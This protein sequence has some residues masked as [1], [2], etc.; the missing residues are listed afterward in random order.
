VTNHRQEYQPLLRC[1][2]I[3]YC[4]T[5][6]CVCLPLRLQADAFPVELDNDENTLSYYGVCDGAQ[7]LMNEIDL[8]ARRRDMERLSI[9]QD[10]RILQ[11]EQDVIAMQEIKQRNQKN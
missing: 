9:E 2:C 5:Q 8:E 3:Y 11:Q 10:Q 1:W 6:L 7:I 4:S